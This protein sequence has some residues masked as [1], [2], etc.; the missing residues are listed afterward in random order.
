MVK[1]VQGLK[2]WCG[3]ALWLAL[4]GCASVTRGD[5]QRLRVET[6]CGSRAVPAQCT[7]SNDRG[8]WQF[9]AP[10]DLVVT[11]DIPLA[12]RVAGRG[13][14]ALNDRGDLFT[15]ENAAERRSLRDRMADLRAAGLAP[16]SPRA[17]ARTARDAKKFADAL[18]RAI[19]GSKPAFRFPS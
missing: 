17:S 11:R 1:H 19:T 13:V 14:A 3:M 7:A 15:A 6:V 4:A 8:R 18:D 2:W 16:E 10:A 12:E 9:R 5:Q